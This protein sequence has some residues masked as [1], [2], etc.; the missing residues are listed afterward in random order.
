MDSI[1][2]VSAYSVDIAWIC[3]EGRKGFY[4]SWHHAVQAVTCLPVHKAN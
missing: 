4:G 1:A 3:G 2:T